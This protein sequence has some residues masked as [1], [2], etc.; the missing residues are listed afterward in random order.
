[1]QQAEKIVSKLRDGADW[2]QLA[3][4]T[5]QQRL[6]DQANRSRE[7][8]AQYQPGEKVWLSLKNISTD[9]PSRTL[10]HRAAQF[11]VIEPVG[12]HAYRLN[13]P[14]GIHDVFHTSLLRRAATD[15]LPSQTI[16]E[17]QPPALVG[18]D[19]NQEWEI[20]DIIRERVFR[21]RREFLVK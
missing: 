14:P 21:R 7:P 1:M 20:N 12:S 9:R 18:E 16:H 15:P 11:T 5:A 13:T 3:L 8:A 4:A 17:P 19:D 2:A 6:E 10:D